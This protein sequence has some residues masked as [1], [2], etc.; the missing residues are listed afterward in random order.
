MKAFNEYGESDTEDDL[1]QTQVQFADVSPALEEEQ[2][3][4]ELNFFL[5]PHHRCAAHTL[6]SQLTL[7]KLLHRVF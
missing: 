5:S 6:K 7:I 1:T 2:E 3:H 4:V